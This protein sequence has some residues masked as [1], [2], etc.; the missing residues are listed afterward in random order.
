MVGRLEDN[1]RVIRSRAEGDKGIEC[2]ETRSYSPD[3]SVDPTDAR[4][5]K[6]K[7]VVCVRPPAWLAAPNTAPPSQA[8]T[9]TVRAAG[10]ASS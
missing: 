3:A 5:A 8:D 1:L 9:R 2:I 7:G 10:I 6:L 4:C